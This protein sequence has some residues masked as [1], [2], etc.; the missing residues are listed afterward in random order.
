MKL[1]I[2]GKIVLSYTVVLLVM[3]AIS[4]LGIQADRKIT[5]EYMNLIERSL[6]GE[7]IIY[8]L[9][10]ELLEKGLALRGYILSGNPAEIERFHLLDENVEQSMDKARMLSQAGKSLQS[11]ELLA[12]INDR[13]DL[14]AED[15]SHLVQLGLTEEAT[16]LMADEGALIL[17]QVDDV[18]AEWVE[19]IEGLNDNWVNTAK[20]T[21]Q[22]KDLFS[23]VGMIA[24][25]A[26]AVIMTIFLNRNITKPVKTIQVAADAVAQG[27]LTVSVPI[28]NT[29]DEIADLATSTRKMV[30]NLTNLL[31]EMQNEAE[32]VASTSEELS[33]SGEESA[34]AAQQISAAIQEMASGAEQQS[35]NAGETAAG[36]QQVAAAIEQI[37]DGAGQQ[38]Q[39]LQNV[40]RLIAQMGQELDH[41]NDFVMKME[42]AINATAKEAE[43]GDR[44]V[45]QVAASMERI[46]NSSNEVEQAAADLEASSRQMVQVVQ[47]IEDIADQ[48]NLL[49]LNAAIE[50]ARAGEQGRGFA[51]V[52]DEVRKLAEGSLN[53]TKVIS[54]LIEQTLAEVGKVASAI[55]GTNDLVEESLPLVIESTEVLHNISNHAANNLELAHSV[56]ESSNSLM[57]GASDVNEATVE[58]VAVADENAAASQQMAASIQQ[59]QKAIE[60]VAAISEEN[61]ASVEEVA[62]S[63]EQITASLQ[64]MS[65]ASHS[66]ADMAARLQQ[67]AARFKLA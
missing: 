24:N 43:K 10:S 56:V 64:Q 57:E 4:I 61:A 16:A 9:R 60:N 65:S 38:T 67:L 29:G 37:A 5:N 19:F 39:Q 20:A 41:V 34:H 51:V 54:G 66:L 33:A 53:E 47:V 8:R 31:S 35:A 40:S 30:E 13:Y 17:G 11:L 14:L 32:Q 55:R 42:E 49:A 28:L 12:E 3:A 46:K 2:G 50:A 45:A 52:A 44:S 7:T 48:T 62:A 59:V 26:I 23:L 18:I 25:I 58:V 27:D 15:I 1:K 63:T 21:G 22:S 36:A 6:P